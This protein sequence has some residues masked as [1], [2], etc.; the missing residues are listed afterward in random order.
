MFSNLPSIF[1]VFPQE[2]WPSMD[3]CAE[4]LAACWPGGCRLVQPGFRRVVSTRS[5]G[6]P[7]NVDRAWNRYVRYPSLAR[8]EASRAGF[9]HVVDHS[10][11]HL[12]RALPEGRAGVYVHDL[13]PFEPFL[14]VRQSR[15]WWHG[16]IQGPVWHGLKRAAVVFCSTS[17]M[18]DRL[19]GLGVWP[20]SRVVLAPL[21]VCQ[22]FKAVGE[23]EPGNYLLHVGSC[24]ARKRMVDLL[25]ILALVR[26][27]VP[28]IRLIQA[29]G[30]FTPE[31]QRLV[32]RLNLQH[33]VEQRRNLTRDDLAR[34][35]RG[36]RAVL[37]PSDSEG[38]GLPVIEA[39]ACGAAVVASDLPT[40]REAGGGAARHVGVGD[41][42]GWAD[43]VM[44]VLDHYDP[45]CGLDHAGQY[46]WSRHAE[47]IA[48]AYSEIH[49]TR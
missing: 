23:R 19:V 6:V 17:A 21:G 30:T 38:F 41:H 2:H 18:R 39:L 11:A 36:A 8:R 37:L 45:Q 40:L 42:A 3:L 9:F 27:R 7:W 13:I 29:G 10:Y 14:N 1:P 34:L 16:L 48:G 46:T 5:R 31:Q 47:I 20:A 28:D 15:P 24:V 12:V 4:R 44:S 35:Y 43:E 25:E 49:T 32:A 26:E 22:E 33:A